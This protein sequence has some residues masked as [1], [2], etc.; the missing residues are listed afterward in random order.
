[1]IFTYIYVYVYIYSQLYP[2]QIIVF[3][4]MFLALLPIAT[5]EVQIQG[6]GHQLQTQGVG[7]QDTFA[8]GKSWTVMD[9][10]S[11]TFQ[12]LVNLEVIIG[13]MWRTSNIYIYIYGE[14]I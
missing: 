8:S 6:A 14:L 3:Q 9:L 5:F 12:N 7:I 1:M 2:H 10:E 13:C 4:P 11:A